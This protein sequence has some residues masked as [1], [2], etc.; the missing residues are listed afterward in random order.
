MKIVVDSNTFIAAL[1]KDSL[2]R[3]ILFSKKIDFYSIL[4]IR[5]DVRKYEH[6]LMEKSGLNSSDFDAVFNLLVSK[7][8]FVEEDILVKFIKQAKTIM[9][10]IDPG[11]SPFIAAVFA[12]NAD[13][14]WSEDKHFESQN[15]VKVFKT[16][17]LIKFI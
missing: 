15:A 7:V 5:M 4:A 11:D 1:L 10:K 14:V 12:I 6:L 3:K 16:K 17:D 8:N 13:G 9:D 2:S